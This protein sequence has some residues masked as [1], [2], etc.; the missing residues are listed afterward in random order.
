[1]SVSIEDEDGSRVALVTGGGSGIGRA[2]AL[3]FARTGVRTVIADIGTTAGEE[4]AH[5]IERAG[6]RALFV[7][8][9]VS[10]S[11]DVE[12][13]VASA[14]NAYSRLDYAFNNAGIGSGGAPIVETREE[15]WDR[16]IAINLKGVWLCMKHECAQMLKQGGGAIVNTSSVMGMIS[17]PGISA[18]SA[19]KAGV[20]GLTRSVA[21]D[22][23]RNGI[24]VNA[25]CPGS[26]WTAMTERPEARV[27]M[28]RIAQ[29]TPMGRL[30][31]PHEIGEAVVWL[32]SAQASFVTGQAFVVDGGFTAL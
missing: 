7:R 14:V 16:T 32:C 27:A 26:V 1:M 22:Y 11:E 18:Y 6:G 31:L 2:A 8:T 20:L 9:D 30:G 25:V 4:T 29:A 19:S 3:A 24:R 21:L 5:L 17:G 23:A 13:L 10:R 15:D 12:A 28:D